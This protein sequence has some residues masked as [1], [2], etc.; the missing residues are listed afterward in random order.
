M[1]KTLLLRILLASLV[2][3]ACVPA[4]P[5]APEPTP[6]PTEVPAPTATP[7]PSGPWWQET[8]FY[9]IFVRSFKDSDG[10]GIGDFNGI[11]QQLDY[12]KGLGV[13]GIW[14]MPIHP[15]PSYH[16]YDV[17]DYLAVNEDYGTLDDF[18]NMLAEAHKR[19]I[20]IILDL[21]LNHTST[22]HPWFKKALQGDPEYKQWYIWSDTDPGFPGPWNAKAWHR[23]SNGQYYY[24]IFWDQMPDLNYDHAPVR[25]EVNKI[26]AF[27]LQEVGIDGFRLDAIRYLDEEG[28]VLADA[29]TTLAF[30]DEWGAF[31]RNLNPEAFTVGEVWTSNSTVAKYTKGQGLD[32]AFNFDLST[33]ILRGLGEGNGTLINFTLEAMKRQFPQQNVSNFLTNHDI[34]RA[35]SYAIG[36]DP[37][38]QGKAAAGLLLTAPGIPFVYYGEEIGMT[39]VKPDEKIRTPMQWTSEPKSGFTTGTPWQAINT[40]YKTINVAAQASDANSL[41]EHYRRLI[42]LRNEN[43]ALRRGLT[44]VVKADAK[45]LVAYLRTSEDQTVLVIINV[46]DQPATDYTLTLENGPLAGEYTLS[47]LFGEGNATPLTVSAAG[48][49]E[50]YTP[51]AEIPPYAVLVFEL[52]P[53]P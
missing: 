14:L 25:E 15:S 52:T 21:V 47:T 49:F 45:R 6:A 27:W 51:L 36:D 10:D 20:K 50:A 40:N 26:T 33:Y 8:V 37:L 5:P 17:T 29:P 23:A 30:L 48:G 9:E 19:D 43:S 28:K 42:L 39:G 2:L 18:K 38:G 1:K 31:V 22:Q 35:A 34:N 32:S 13:R 12:L 11:T 3:A 41:L 4:T 7:E 24:A 53:K 46:D 44:E 16:G